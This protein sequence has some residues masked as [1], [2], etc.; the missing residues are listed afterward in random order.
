MLFY[1]DEGSE[2]GGLIFGG[3]KNE[4]GDVVDSGASLSFDKYGAGQIVQLAGIDDATDH[5]AGLA[6]NGK[7]GRIWVGTTSDGNATISLKDANGKDRILM[8]VPEEGNPSVAFLDENGQI[9]KR[10]LP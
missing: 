9:V 4:K 3:H 10:L 8:Q 7:G 1:N 6:V 2:N 5:F